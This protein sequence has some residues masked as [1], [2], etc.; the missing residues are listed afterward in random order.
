M[1]L[2]HLSESRLSHL[3]KAETGMNLKNYMVMMRM[4]KAFMLIN[5]GQSFTE[6][7]VNA[8]FYDSAHLCKVV[9]KYTGITVSDVFKKS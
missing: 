1:L 4:K 7:A 8:A 5:S 3:F 2:L 6:A 9:K